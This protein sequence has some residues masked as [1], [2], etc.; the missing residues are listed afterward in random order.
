MTQQY[1]IGELS[2]LLAEL[3]PAPG[4]VLADAVDHLRQE[5]EAGPPEHVHVLA[6]E[7]MTLADAICWAALEQGDLE[8]FS[9][10]AERTT[11]LG[12]FTDSARW[13]LR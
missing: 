4:R 10:Y 1:L 7:A 11:R 13:L 8:G 2:L 6:L 5:I 9:R 12:E 3:Q